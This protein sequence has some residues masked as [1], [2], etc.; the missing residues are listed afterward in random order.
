M[1]IIKYN[2]YHHY[3]FQV[4]VTGA[5]VTLDPSMLESCVR[6]NLNNSA[7]R[8]MAVLD[9]IKVTISNF[10]NA[11]VSLFCS[12]TFESYY[13]SLTLELTILCFGVI[14]TEQFK[15]S[16]FLTVIQ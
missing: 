14:K 1:Q 12:I 3:P 8:V 6:D 5:L 2:L 13:G 9:P 15:H 11:K 16:F 10:P 7:P 4:G